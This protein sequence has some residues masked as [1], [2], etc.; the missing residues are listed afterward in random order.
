[1]SSVRKLTIIFSKFQAI[2]PQGRDFILVEGVKMCENNNKNNGD[3]MTMKM[4]MTTMMMMITTTTTTIKMMMMSY[5]KIYSGAGS[6][7]RQEL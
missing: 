5:D 2:S 3:Q 6:L 4:T 7:G 1:M